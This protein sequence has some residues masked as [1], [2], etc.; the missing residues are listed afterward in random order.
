M[1]YVSLFIAKYAVRLLLRKNT[2]ASIRNFEITT[3]CNF[4]RTHKDLEIEH[5][6]CQYIYIHD[7]IH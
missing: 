1:E 3:K 2:F 4:T 6:L 5:I 7:S